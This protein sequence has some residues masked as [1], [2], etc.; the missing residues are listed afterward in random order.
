MIVTNDFDIKKHLK[1]KS[2]VALGCFDALHIGHMRIIRQMAKYARENNC[3]AVVQIIDFED[4][5][6]EKIN[7][8]KERIDILADAGVDIV[9][10][11]KFDDDFKRTTYRDF[12]FHHL[13][14]NYNAEAVFVGFNYRF[15]HL[16]EGDAEKL[17]IECKKY[18]IRVFVQP[19]VNMNGIVSSTRIRNLLAEGRV[20]SA[21]M[22]MGRRYSVSGEIDKGKALGR[23]MGFP[24]ANMEMPKGCAL[25]KDG[26]YSTIVRIDGDSFWGITN[27]GGKPTVSDNYKNIET[28]II[29]FNGDLY[30]KEIEIE[31]YKRIR[32]VI[33]FETLDG[34]KTQIEKDRVFTIRQKRKL[35]LSKEY[36]NRLC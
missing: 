23:E 20:N 11:A 25:P 28:N 7:T 24:T 17:T 31:F 12:V 36:K 6:R 27:V 22:I 5:R 21:S 15:G 4:N 30:G 18:G 34:L 32:N 9:V 26:V 16:A 33:K 10:V 8:L 19:S 1:I 35:C 29:G 13:N 2:A 3:A 14:E